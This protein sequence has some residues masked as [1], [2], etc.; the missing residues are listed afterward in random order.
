MKAMVARSYGSP[1]VL[2]LQEVPAPV[3]MDD[4]VLV[5]VRA[6]SLNAADWHVLRAD[7]FL[8][9]LMFGPFR[10]K[11]PIL[12]ADVAG[13]VE[14]VGSRVTRF[15][16]GDAVF[17]DLALY[18]WG[19]F[20]EFT[21]ATEDL[22]A[23]MPAGLSFEE[24]AAIPLAAVTA[25]QA[26]RDVGRLKAGMTVAVNG[27][28]GGV[29]TFAV[30][31]A[32]ALG[33]EV[34]AVCSARNLELARSLGADHVIDYG[35]EDFTRS[36]RRYDL[37]LAANGYHPLADY[38]RALSDHGSYV[39]SG[40]A[41]KQMAAAVLAGPWRSMVGGKRFGRVDAKG[42]ARDL[43]VVK[44]MVEAGR[45][46]PVIDRRYRLEQLPEALRY[47]EEGHARGKVVIAVRA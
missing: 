15:K 8:V 11:H 42:N 34:T 27:A 37:I 39:M 13:T 12:G 18:R 19:G 35:E 17:G 22:L 32:K 10:P 5:A 44:G 9:R 29:G 33:A 23:P 14:A 2:S 47:L 43:E 46:R 41:G 7:P 6:S 28:S 16:P 38:G 3:P 26:L 21:C 40:G 31:I 36:G 25:L 24:A 45:V 20:G 1:D 4:E 30:Q